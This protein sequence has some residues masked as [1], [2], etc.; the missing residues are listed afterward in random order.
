M[1]IPVKVRAT[2]SE[3]LEQGQCIIS[4]TKSLDLEIRTRSKVVQWGVDTMN[5]HRAATN[6]GN[7]TMLWNRKHSER[8]SGLESSKQD[9]CQ[10]LL[11]NERGHVGLPSH[12][13]RP[14]GQLCHR[15][16][17]RD[18]IPGD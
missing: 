14:R 12:L 10:K 4:E 2:N 8:E 7:R 18:N 9:L 11:Y 17:W 6:M 3:E 15:T 1:G 16:D 5:W 13:L